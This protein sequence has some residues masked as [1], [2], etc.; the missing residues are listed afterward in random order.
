MDG[1]FNRQKRKEIL[2]QKKNKRIVR[3]CIDD[4]EN[5]H[6]N[7]LSL[8]RAQSSVTP[9]TSMGASS[10]PQMSSNNFIGNTN[11]TRVVNQGKLIIYQILLIAI[12]LKLHTN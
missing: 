6:P 11:N 12:V 4:K 5:Y 9:F 8:S 2:S 7:D 10:N 3:P 1:S